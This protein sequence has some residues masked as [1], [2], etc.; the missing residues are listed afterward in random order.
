MRKKLHHKIAQFTDA[1]QLRP[2]DFILISEQLNPAR[3][4]KSLLAV[5]G[6]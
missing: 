3:T 6:Y 5:N 1:Q 2:K 4:P